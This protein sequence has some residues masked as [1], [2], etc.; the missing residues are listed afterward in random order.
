[1][2]VEGEEG[3]RNWLWKGQGGFFVSFLGGVPLPYGGRER[4]EA[5]NCFQGMWARVGG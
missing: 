5:I 1:M 3:G 2:E 4:V